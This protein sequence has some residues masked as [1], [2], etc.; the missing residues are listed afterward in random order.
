M[1]EL[2][3]EQRQE[4]TGPEP[5]AVDPVTNTTY[6]LVREDVYQRLKAIVSEVP[7]LTTADV[8]DKVMAEDDL[9]DP[10]LAEL[11]KKY[12]GHGA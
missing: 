10:W 6:V 5:R 4:M 12:G 2:T 8:L 9:N 3:E 7:V 1:I 11:Q